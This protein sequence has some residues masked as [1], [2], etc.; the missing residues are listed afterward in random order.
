MGVEKERLDKLGVGAL[1]AGAKTAPDSVRSRESNLPPNFE[2]SN[3]ARSPETTLADLLQ[4]LNRMTSEYEAAKRRD[5]ERFS[6]IIQ[7]TT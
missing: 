2:N 1:P 6:Y 4:T 7:A 3:E 5:E